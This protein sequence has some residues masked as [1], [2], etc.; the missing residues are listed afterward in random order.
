MSTS[1][2]LQ[3][4]RL[5]EASTETNWWSKA[6]EWAVLLFI[7]VFGVYIGYLLA[8]RSEQRRE[9]VRAHVRTKV[10]LLNVRAEFELPAWF[11]HEGHMQMI[12]GGSVDF[13][14][15]ELQLHKMAAFAGR[16]AMVQGEI[17]FLLPEIEQSAQPMIRSWYELSELISVILTGPR[18]EYSGD[19]GLLHR[20]N[21]KRLLEVGTD[22]QK[23]LVDLIA[24]LGT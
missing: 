13:R 16:I 18:N 21:L 17:Q 23:S 1:D 11:I 24:E 19:L 15:L 10:N 8:S 5:I 22:F 3:I 20:Q 14:N 2:Y 6:V 7:G 9:H 12:Q 4:V